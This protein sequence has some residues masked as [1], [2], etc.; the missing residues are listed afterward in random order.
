MKN[1]YIAQRI[2]FFLLL[3]LTVGML[4]YTIYGM[5][6]LIREGDAT[7]F[8]W[9][10]AIVFY[11]MVF[12]IPVGAATFVLLTL[13]AK[14]RKLSE[15]NGLKAYSVKMLQYYIIAYVVIVGLL[16]LSMAPILPQTN[17]S[18]VFLFCSFGL[19]VACTVLLLVKSTRITR[20]PKENW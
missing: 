5:V 12:I 10:F 9:W 11:Q 18:D 14:Y 4:A 7:S 6:G 16:A 17:L 15:G 2:L 1:T 20:P 13:N 19:M 8:P 3:V